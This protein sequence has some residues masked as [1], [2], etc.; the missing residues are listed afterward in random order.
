LD[1]TINNEFITENGE[2]IFHIY[3]LH[4]R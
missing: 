1:F 2:Q 3:F 4:L